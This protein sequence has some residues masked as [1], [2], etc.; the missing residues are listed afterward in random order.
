MRVAFEREVFQGLV[1]AASVA[2]LAVSPVAA[3]DP[4]ADPGAVRVLLEGRVAAVEADPGLDD[5][6]RADTL[7]LYRQSRQQLDAIV[8]NLATAEEY[9]SAIDTAPAEA[10][11]IRAAT[12][13]QTEVDPL[14]GLDIQSTDTLDELD[15]LLQGAHA[16]LSTAE[17]QLDQLD[18]ALETESGRPALARERIDAAR[19]QT[20]EAEAQLGGAALANENPLVTDARRAWVEVRTAALGAEIGVLEQEL[21]SQSARLDLLNAR[22]DAAVLSVLHAGLRVDYLTQIVADQFRTDGDEAVDQA[23]AMLA[24][25]LVTH[26][27]VRQTAETNIALVEELQTQISEFESTAEQGREI[28][29]LSTRIAAALR[30]TVRKLELDRFGAPLGQGIREERQQFPTAVSFAELRSD[31]QTQIATASLRRIESEDN[32]RLISDYEIYLERE[33]GL[34]AFDLGSVERAQLE[35]LADSRRSLL[36]L[37]IA[38]DAAQLQQLYEFDDLLIELSETLEAY[39]QLLAE[40]LFRVRTSEA[41]SL[42]DLAGIGQELGLQFSPA[43]WMVAGTLLVA[44]IFQASAWSLLLVGAIMVVAQRRRLRQA[45]DRTKRNVGMVTSDSIAE[46]VKALALTVLRALPLPAI[47]FCLGQLLNSAAEPTV[48]STS[49]AVALIE[50]TDPL[51]SFVLFREVFAPDGPAGTHFRWNR[52]ALVQ[53][54]RQM[55]WFLVAFTPAL[56]LASLW[57]VLTPG[58]MGGAVGFLEVSILLLLMSALFA[59]VLNP[60]SGPLRPYFRAHQE[61]ILRRARFVWIPV[62]VLL[63]IVLVILHASGFRHVSLEILRRIADT[64]WLVLGVVVFAG[65][66]ER[67]LLIARRRLMREA[68]IRERELAAKAAE[69][70]G[71]AMEE[72]P[73]L[74]GIGSQTDLVALDTGSKKLLVALIAVASVVGFLLIWNDLL[75]AFVVL[76][77]LSLWSRSVVVDGL[78]QALPVTLQDLLLALVIGLLGYIAARDFPALL[79]IILLRYETVSAGSRYAIT[80]LS[81]Y[82]IVSVAVLGVLG[83]LG[84][85]WSQM[86]WA[87]AALSVGIGF[88]LQEIVANFISGL[89]LLFERP[90]RVGDVITVGDASGTVTR[91][92]IRATTVRDFD[93]KE[94]IVPNKEFITGRLLNWTLSDPVTRILVTVGVAYGTDVQKAMDLMRESAEENERVLEDPPPYVIFEQFSD[95]SLTL[96]LRAWV[97]SFPDRLP[98]MTQINQAINERFNDTGIVIAFPQQDVHVYS[99]NPYDVPSEDDVAPDPT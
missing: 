25:P 64:L 60:R 30:S 13:E 94:L 29:V 39:D 90:I 53:F 65:F 20:A 1:L 91:I 96:T 5:R 12:E 97:G 44:S 22:R 85:S 38:S 61:A 81:R 73:D 36:D 89:I 77:N 55:T 80:T 45:I 35:P 4:L 58:T 50:M 88:G 28:E 23:V 14:A 27:I 56:F 8:V 54:H 48:F 59:A 75:P 51:L 47:T 71:S 70:D 93:R 42:S 99:H 21:L 15:Q 37:S 32:L 18:A 87:V 52:D 26:P 67:W 78:A 76:D 43:S 19:V 6:T 83:M 57:F 33:M 34:A 17:T 7:E 84:A 11:A 66:A 41:L 98:V 24:D 9:L 16:D 2:M 63:P 92:R 82:A 74:D 10:A 46:T 72:D 62:V 86:G 95:S 69:D 49:V 40:Q 68:A 79:E 31:V 3:Q